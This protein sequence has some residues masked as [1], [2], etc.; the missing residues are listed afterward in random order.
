MARWLTLAVVLAA[1][2]ALAC[3]NGE[4]E[5]N[6]YYNE[7][8][9]EAL[10]LIAKANGEFAGQ[11]F[12]GAL[13]HAE[14]ALEELGSESPRDADVRRAHLIA[15]QAAL[16]LGKYAAAEE[17]LAPYGDERSATA[18]VK[19][20]LAEARVGTDQAARALPVLEALAKEDRMPDGQAWVALM[21]AR[22][23]TGDQAGAAE[24]A[25]EALG[26]DPRNRAALALLHPERLETRS[27]V[28]VAGALGVS[29][30]GL[31]LVL[32]R[33]RGRL[34]ARPKGE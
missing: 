8:E 32:A 5:A 4:F 14:A 19:A 7:P 10:R 23:A 18:L 34:L 25:R 2:A 31:A 24:A 30:A 33:R 26:R 9:T 20:R 27:Q 15:G 28:P 11:D 21:R 1:P 16:K 3:V 12:K 6:P 29:F 22:Q 17:H 13:K